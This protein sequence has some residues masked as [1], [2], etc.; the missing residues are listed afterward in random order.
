M[1]AILRLT[2]Y[3][4]CRH[5]QKWVASLKRN[6]IYK[7]APARNESELSAWFSLYISADEER[8]STESINLSGALFDV[9]ISN[10]KFSFLYKNE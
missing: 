1:D 10:M 8:K 2:M 7:C 3:V 6:V 4:R 9:E 5:Q